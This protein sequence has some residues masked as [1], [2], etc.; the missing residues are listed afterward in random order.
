MNWKPFIFLV[1]VSLL[2][3]G[4]VLLLVRHPWVTDQLSPHRTEE[5]RYSRSVEPAPDALPKKAWH[6]DGNGRDEVSQEQREKIRQLEAI[7]YVSGVNESS[8]GL[9]A[10]FARLLNQL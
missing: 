7:G 10:I 9:S 2:F 5:T 1:C 4:L 6:L 8:K 3:A